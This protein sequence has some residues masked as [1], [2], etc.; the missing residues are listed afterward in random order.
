[1]LAPRLSKFLFISFVSSFTIKMLGFSSSVA[2]TVVCSWLDCSRRFSRTGSAGSP[3][4][5][6]P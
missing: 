6:R 2:R 4:V 1:M 3:A 5:T